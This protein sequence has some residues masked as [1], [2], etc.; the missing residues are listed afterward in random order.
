V[1]IFQSFRF[2]GLFWNVFAGHQFAQMDF[3]MQLMAPPTRIQVKE[4]GFL[5]HWTGERFTISAMDRSLAAGGG[6][7]GKLPFK[8]SWK[9]RSHGGCSWI[10]MDFR[11]FFVGFG[12]FSW[13]FMDFRGFLWIFVDFHGF[14]WVL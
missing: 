1:T 12:G 9:W 10:F 2:T 13:I 14:S 5:L 6:A 7:K 3:P 8:D 11:G 4:L